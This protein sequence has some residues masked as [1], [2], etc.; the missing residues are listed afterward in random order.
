MEAQTT[1]DD[2]PHGFGGWWKRHVTIGV[3]YED[4]VARIDDD[5]GLS[6]RYLFMTLMSAGIAILGLLQ[7]SPA[8]VIG[9]M[10]ISPLMGPI[11]GLGFA[12]ALFDFRE[13]GRSLTALMFG[14][15]VAVAATALVTFVSPLQ[16]VTAEI[17]SRTR[18]NLFDLLIALFSA[19]AG[20]YAMIR[21]RSGTIVGVAIATALM[22]PLAVVGFG[23]ATWNATVF[24]GAVLLFVTN[25]ITIAMTAALMARIYGFGA[26]LSPS[27]TRVQAGLLI[28]VFIALSIPLALA[29]KRIAWE[30]FASRTIRNA[31]LAPFPTDARASQVEIDFDRRPI[32]V[33]A[34]VLT[35]KMVGGI[36][37]RVTNAVTQIARPRRRRSYRRAR[38]WRGE[39][40]KRGGA[41]RAGAV[42]GWRQAGR[43][44]PACIRCD[45]AAGVDRRRQPG[46]G[47]DRSRQSP[48]DRPRAAAAGRDA[49]FVPGAR[50]AR[51]RTASVGWSIELMP[52]GRSRAART[53][54]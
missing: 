44:R 6:Q 38:R 43:S 21:G 50:G 19:L 23:L 11:M 46:C 18:P 9:A 33:N 51:G 39:R 34:V 42:R 3:D 15:L 10:L 48:R 14:S 47:H 24:G 12:I 49:R 52:A 45:A 28:V 2:H 54:R 32:R 36:D 26:R 5:A 41:D 22:P 13:M 40:R 35:S 7:S 29:L 17:A 31:V 20:A 16:T 1:G 25:F 37:E 8:V 53:L 27:Q 4:V 30:S